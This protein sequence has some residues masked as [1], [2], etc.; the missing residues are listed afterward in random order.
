MTAHAE[1]YLITGYTSQSAGTAT[2]SFGNVNSSQAQG[3][4]GPHDSRAGYLKAGEPGGIDPV[5]QNS[6]GTNTEVK[7]ALRGTAGNPYGDPQH[8]PKAP[9]VFRGWTVQQTH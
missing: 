3:S 9:V 8:N 4:P 6:A 5:I 1:P 2:Y 7:D